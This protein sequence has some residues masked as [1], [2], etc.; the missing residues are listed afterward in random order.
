LALRDKDG[1]EGEIWDRSQGFVAYA[2]P[3]YEGSAVKRDVPAAEQSRISALARSSIDAGA[4][5]LE[6][7]RGKREASIVA[8]CPL[9]GGTAMASWTLKRLPAELAEV[10]DRL[11]FGPG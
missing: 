10:Y 2:F 4:P 3:T 1:V 5:Q 6:M 11:A 7:Q 8:A 9:A